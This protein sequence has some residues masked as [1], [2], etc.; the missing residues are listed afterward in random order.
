MRRAWFAAA[1]AA[2]LVAF[3]FA[4]GGGAAGAANLPF[5]TL[6]VTGGS[7]TTFTS[8]DVTS[9]ALPSAPNLTVQVN[10][11]TV[12]GGTITITSPV[13]PIGAGGATLDLGTITA[14][15]SDMNNTGWL[16]GGS[17]PLVPGGTSLPCATIAPLVVLGATT[18][19]VVLTMNVTSATA[20]TWT[21]PGF[22]F[23]G[24]AN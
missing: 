6:N 2:A 5:L 9:T 10:V 3:A 1:L 17:T 20:D 14:T 15:C 19:K 11:T 12:V 4:T 8:T 16:I 7:P 21:V 18:M 24:I 23:G 13:D 22:A